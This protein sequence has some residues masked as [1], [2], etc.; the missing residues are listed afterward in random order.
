MSATALALRCFA[1]RAAQAIE[2][3]AARERIGFACFAVEDYL[4]GVF[5]VAAFV[6][7]G[8]G[9]YFLYSRKRLVA[10]APEEEIALIAAAESELARSAD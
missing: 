9:Y 6:L 8:M 4:P 7:V 1:D 5:G 10:Q 3:E 2:G